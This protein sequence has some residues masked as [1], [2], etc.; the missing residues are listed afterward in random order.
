VY[1]QYH[2]DAIKA[3]FTSGLSHIMTRQEFLKMK[4]NGDYVNSIVS[5]S[6]TGYMLGVRD[7]L[8]SQKLKEED[9]D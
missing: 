4:P 6:W 3:A 7:V 9:N 2:S 8:E 1:E 5:N